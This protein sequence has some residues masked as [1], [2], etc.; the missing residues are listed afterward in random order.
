MTVKGSSSPPSRVILTLNEYKEYIHRTQATQSASIS[1]V[2]QT[3]NSSACLSHSSGPWIL[4][5]G[6]SDHISGNKYLFSSF[7]ITSPLPM[8]TL[9]NGSPTMAKEIGS[10]SLFPSIPLTFVLYVPDSPFNLLFISKLTRDL[11][12]FITVE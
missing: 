1:F 11:N 5:F 3:G 7:T 6:A 8:I 9:A 12:C 10:A 4:D 2:V